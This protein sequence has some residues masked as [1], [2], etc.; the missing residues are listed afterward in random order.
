MTTRR[1]LVAAGLSTASLLFLA[2]PGYASTGSLAVVRGATGQ[3]VEF[4]PGGASPAVRLGDAE[5]LVT[6]PTLSEFTPAN[7]LFAAWDDSSVGGDRHFVTVSKDGGNSW[8]RPQALTYDI[9][10]RAGVLRPGQSEPS[11]AAELRS[12]PENNLYIV[13]FQTNGLQAWRDRLTQLGAE[14]LSPLPEHA[15]IVRMPAA[16]AGQVRGESFVRWVGAYEPGYRV[17]PEILDTLR[18]QAFSPATTTYYVQTFTPGTGEK[19]LLASEVRALGGQVVENIPNGY[20]LEASL[21][22]MQV[23]SLAHSDHVLWIERKTARS[24]D[25]NGVRKDSGANYVVNVGGYNGTGVRGEVLDAGTQKSPYHIDFDG[26]LE[27]GTV[28]FDSHGASTYGIVFGNGA[29]DGDGS[30]KATGMMFAAQQGYIADYDFLVDRYAETADLVTAP[31][32]VVFQSNSWGDAQTPVY[33]SISSQMDD[34]IW[35]N[36]IAI[37][38][39]QSN[40]GNTQSRPQAWAK[41]II[42]IGAVNHRNTATVADDCWCSGASIGPA[43]DGRLKPDLAYWYDLILTTTSGGT[44]NQYITNFGGTSAATP[45]TAGAGGLM[46]QMWANNL[47]GTNPVGTTVFD[48]RPHSSTMKALM[49]NSALQY[50][51]SGTTVDLTRTHQGWGRTN[52]KLAYDRAPLTKVI[53]ETEVL[54]EFQSK[55]YTMVVPAGQTELKVTMVYQDRAGTTSSTL[56][57]IN[58]VTLKVVSPGGTIYWGNNGL[59]AGNYSTA[60]GSPNTIDTVENVFLQNPAAGNW[61]ITVSADDLNQ[62]VHA[63]TP[64]VDQDYALVAY[65]ATSLN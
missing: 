49:I 28:S 36:D 6:H 13:Q 54:T 51:F 20:L 57:R 17:E 14:V 4:H 21:T 53:N 10:L 15:H 32:N 63:E 64:G 5:G 46:F 62:D 43:Q 30:A 16:V 19:G 29:F 35:I 2:L 27:H 12:R 45:M 61:T 59:A 58:D 42:S 55:V 56:H 65:P 39:S 60:G 25:M 37:F 7:V 3:A 52:L 34:I 9:P 24:N 31:M 33:T 23:L 47:W 18:A 44:G 50:T 41:N 8:S 22:P 48:K 1:R 11:V 40:L 26:I 38:Q